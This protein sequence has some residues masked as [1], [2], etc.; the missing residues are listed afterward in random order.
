MER[1][2]AIPEALPAPAAAR[3]GAVE[4]AVLYDAFAWRARPYVPKGAC[5]FTAH[6]RSGIATTFGFMAGVSV[7]DA[8][9]VHLVCG[10]VELRGGV[11]AHRPEYLRSHL[12]RFCTGRSR[13]SR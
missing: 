5:S 2:T 9:L 10:A 11:D 7:M 6:E 3:V 12:T 13:R 1:N 8:L 4:A